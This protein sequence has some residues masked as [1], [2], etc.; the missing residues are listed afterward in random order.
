MAPRKVLLYTVC[1]LLIGTADFVRRFES[2]NNYLTLGYIVLGAL[3]LYLWFR[4]DA[5]N[6]T[7]GVVVIGICMALALSGVMLYL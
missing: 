2:G 7:I 6:A 4:E 3:F 5:P 1:V